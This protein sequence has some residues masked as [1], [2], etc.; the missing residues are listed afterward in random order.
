MY[1]HVKRCPSKILVITAICAL[2]LGSGR[3]FWLWGAKRDFQR[4][5]LHSSFALLMGIILTFPSEQ[6]LHRTV[7]HFLSESKV[8]VTVEDEDASTILDSSSLVCYIQHIR[9]LFRWRWAPV[10]QRRVDCADTNGRPEYSRPRIIP[11]GLH[12]CSRCHGDLS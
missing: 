7:L 4:L 1:G 5:A 2:L 8:C 3:R 6:A 12:N 9:V 11:G 10:S